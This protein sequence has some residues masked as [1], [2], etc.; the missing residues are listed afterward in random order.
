M[1][2]GYLPKEMLEHG[3]GQ[4][5]GTA[6][7]AHAPGEAGVGT[8]KLAP[9]AGATRGVPQNFPGGREGALQRKGWQQ[10]RGPEHCLQPCGLV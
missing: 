3:R 2:A 10:E 5:V 1:P 8:A 9:P 6:K 4:G 7:L